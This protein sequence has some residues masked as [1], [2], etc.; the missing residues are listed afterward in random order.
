M[1]DL[2]V[3]GAD[4]EVQNWSARACAYV[5]VL[6]PEHVHMGT[7]LARPESQLLSHINVV[8]MRRDPKSRASREQ[9]HLEV[10]GRIVT[11]HVVAVVTAHHWILRV[12]L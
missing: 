9:V 12:Q 6:W 10:G 11:A 5:Q 8:P 1:K 4:S 7:Y 3:K 2:N